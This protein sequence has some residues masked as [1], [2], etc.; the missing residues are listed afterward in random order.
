MNCSGR[1][2]YKNPAGT[3]WHRRRGP[4][5]MAGMIRTARLPVD[6]IV[7]GHRRRPVNLTH[8][9]D[10]ADSISTLG[11]LQHLVVTE[12]NKLVA[13]GHRLEA[14][15]RLGWTTVPVTVIELSDLQADLAAI[16]ENLV[17]NDLSR[18]ER[19]EHVV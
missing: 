5:S 18:L 9:A 3:L 14:V 17:R 8:V 6:E 4:C 16:D 19:F 7:V 11:L 1:H 12:Q 13:G 15:K 10:L 2:G